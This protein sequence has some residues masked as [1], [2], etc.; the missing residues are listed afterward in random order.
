[1]RRIKYTDEQ[2]LDMI[3]DAERRLGR[4]P[5]SREIQK[6]QQAR[7]RTRFGSWENAVR[8][9]LGKKS[10]RHQWSDAEIL[11]VFRK[12]RSEKQRFPTHEDL[13]SVSNSFCITVIRR[14]GSIDEA[15]LRALGTNLH[16]EALR[17]IGDLTPPSCA[18][19]SV[20]EIVAW[21]NKRGL[22]HSTWELDRR[23]RL[24][25]RDGL[26]ERESAMPKC[27]KLTAK[28]REHDRI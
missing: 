4:V 19:A 1:M 27:W 18:A 15:A 12:L 26:I 25:K 10:N 3:R 16:R 5:T 7:I 24:L 14:F 28:G 9:A 8:R 6:T 13:K 20:Y 2:L 11:D 22:R 21:L 23:L 17:A